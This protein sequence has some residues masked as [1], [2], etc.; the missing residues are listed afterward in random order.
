MGLM[1]KKKK[2]LLYANKSIT[3]EFKSIR[4]NVKK[5]MF[6]YENFPI[7]CSINEEE[8]FVNIRSS[9]CIYKSNICKVESFS[10]LFWISF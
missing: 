8:S 6:N 1:K 2:M 4:K 7:S 9:N 3:P 5:P 10:Q